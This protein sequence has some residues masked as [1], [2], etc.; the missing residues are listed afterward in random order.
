MDLTASGAEDLESRA[1]WEEV[2]D[3]VLSFLWLTGLAKV[4]LAL[5]R[6]GGGGSGSSAS[7]SI[8]VIVNVLVDR[9]SCFTSSGAGATRLERWNRLALL[10]P[11]PTF[12]SSTEAGAVKAF[13][14]CCFCCFSKAALAALAA[15]TLICRVGGGLASFLASLSLNAVETAPSFSAKLVFLD[16]LFLSSSSNTRSTVTMLAKLNWNRF[17]FCTSLTTDMVEPR[18]FTAFGFRSIV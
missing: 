14:S 1:T 16:F 15:T 7:A 17:P 10:A 11:P 4:V 3:K 5:G 8:A 13:A 9:S 18:L 2:R 6:A 12:C